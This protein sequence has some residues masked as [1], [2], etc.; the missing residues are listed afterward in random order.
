MTSLPKG[1]GGLAPANLQANSYGDARR[2]VEK[3]K[4][5]EFEMISKPFGSFMIFS[6]AMQLKQ[7]N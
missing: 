2:G 3:L 5:G 1:R 7:E 6:S 4:Y